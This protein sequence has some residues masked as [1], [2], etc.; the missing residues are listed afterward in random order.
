MGGETSTS[1]ADN[2]KTF[3]LVEAAYDSAAS[4]QT[5]DIGR[6]FDELAVDAFR[7]YGTHALE[8]P[9]VR[10][11]AGRLTADLNDGN[12]RTISYDGVEVLRAVSY[13]VRDRDWG[14]YAPEITNLKID[15]K[16]DA[17][18]VGYTALC[19]GPDTTA[20]RSTSAFRRRPARPCSS[21]RMRSRHRLR[22][23]PLRLLHPAS[24]RRR[25]RNARDGRAR[26][27]KRVETRFPDLI[28]PWQPFKDMSAITHT[29]I[30]A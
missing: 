11:T 22:D 28:E 9:P 27:G 8:Q 1:G 4:G 16:D 2:L 21:K 13:L 12:L 10:L 29:V 30:P 26:D 5:V 6:C 25:C 3:A 20:L 14:T 19:K 23:Q 7:I 17:F 18:S 24:D 15:Q